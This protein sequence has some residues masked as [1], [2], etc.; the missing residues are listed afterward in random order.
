MISGQRVA[1]AVLSESFGWVT[2][3]AQHSTLLDQ[4]GCSA[5]MHAWMR[6]QMLHWHAQLRQTLEVCTPANRWLVL[7]LQLMLVV[8]AILRARLGR[9]RHP[10][11]LV[12]LSASQLVSSHTSI[13]T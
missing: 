12:Q 9:G 3:A 13:I 5:D 6:K 1:S 10:P 7:G 11:S 4:Q 2:V 8:A